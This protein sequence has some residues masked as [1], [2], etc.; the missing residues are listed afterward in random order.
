MKKGS[1]ANAR[2][3]KKAKAAALPPP[4]SDVLKYLN[5]DYLSE[6]HAQ[7]LKAEFAQKPFPHAGLTNFLD[8][9]FLRNVKEQLVT[10]EEWFV[11]NNDLYSFAQTDALQKSQQVR[12]HSMKS[13]LIRRMPAL[14]DPGCMVCHA[15]FVPSSCD[16]T[17]LN[18]FFNWICLLFATIYADV[19]RATALRQGNEPN[20]LQCGIP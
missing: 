3:Q 11:K 20:H 7:K 12:F 19:T 2:G 5:K 10:N 6:E 15:Y 17:E 4:D 16:I 1:G 13:W 9:G 14:C 18:R 8:D